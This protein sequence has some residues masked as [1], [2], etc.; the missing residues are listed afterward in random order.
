MIV[1]NN[2]NIYILEMYYG[3]FFKHMNY[4]LVI[5]MKFELFFVITFIYIF[6]S[7]THT[8]FTA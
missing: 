4:S 5:N 7:H 1:Q 3:F 6:F 8:F 2:K